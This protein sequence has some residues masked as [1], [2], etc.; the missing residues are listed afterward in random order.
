M[1]FLAGGP[2][3]P[4]LYEVDPRLRPFGSSGPL[5]LPL[6]AF[7]DYHLNGTAQGWERL[8]LT[9][10]RVLGPPGRFASQVEATIR[11]ILTRHDLG[12]PRHLAR[13][14]RDLRDRIG[15][16]RPAHDLKRGLAGTLDVE[17]IVQSLGRAGRASGSR[18]VESHRPSPT[19][20]GLRPV[21]RS[22]ESGTVGASSRG[23]RASRDGRGLG[24]PGPTLG[25]TP[26]HP[27]RSSQP[28]PPLPR[29]GHPSRPT[30]P[31]LV[32][33]D[34]GLR[35]APARR[36]RE[37]REFNPRWHDSSRLTK[38]RGRPTIMSLL[39]ATRRS[40]RTPAADPGALLSGSVMFS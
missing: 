13:L 12:P 5:A 20:G 24:S 34:R 18:F 39:G 21:A 27:C 16:G 29:R 19:F 36:R 26:D 31:R 40:P 11:H 14:T 9:R 25:I 32:R 7:A 2:D 17:F 33:S 28:G 38:R 10:A 30:R 6:R 1:K 23:R 4:A 3:R 35:A 37:G 8:A 22:K 15:R